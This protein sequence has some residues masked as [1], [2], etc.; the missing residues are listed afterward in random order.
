MII[1]HYDEVVQYSNETLNLQ[2][3][4]TNF[5]ISSV[6]LSWSLSLLPYHLQF[7]PLS[8]LVSL[9]IVHVPSFS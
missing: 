1:V 3:G 9:F 7:H 6:L 4:Y 5:S 2:L 8:L